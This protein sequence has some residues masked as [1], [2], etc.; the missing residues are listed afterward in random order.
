MKHVILS[1]LIVLLSL[2]RLEAH[3]FLERAEP[4]VGSTVREFHAGILAAS[5]PARE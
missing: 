2:A 5:R 1:L 3:A 4:Q